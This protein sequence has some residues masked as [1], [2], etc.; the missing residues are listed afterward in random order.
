MHA[1]NNLLMQVQLFNHLIQD[2]I[3]IKMI[4]RISSF[5]LLKKNRSIEM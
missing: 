4:S 1:G 5:V 3:C 2:R